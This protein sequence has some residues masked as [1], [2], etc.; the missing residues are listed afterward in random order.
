MLGVSRPTIYSRIRSG[1]LLAVQV[2]PRTIR[3][4]VEELRAQQVRYAPAPSSIK[5]IRSALETMMT[6][7]EAIEK[8]GISQQWFYKKV[9]AAGIK[10]MR[11]GTMVLYPKAAIHKLFYRRRYP[12]ITDWTTS[13]ELAKE[14]GV[15]RKTICTLARKYDIPRVR[16]KRNL[17]ISRKDWFLHRVEMPDLKKN[18]LTVA[19]AKKHYHIGPSTFYDGVNANDIPRRRQGREVYYAIADL[20][21]LFKDRSPKIPEEIRRNYVTAGDALRIY[22]IG[23]KRFSEETRAAGVTKIRTEGN[24]VW[25]KKQELDKLFIR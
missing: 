17:L 14:F 2:A 20:D 7:D 12:E 18:Y 16:T 6:R 23:Q 19:Q 9:K 22:R 25:Y 8:Y 11:Y 24:F 13:E 1:E 5:D 3:I 21:R 15:G 10:A 4:P